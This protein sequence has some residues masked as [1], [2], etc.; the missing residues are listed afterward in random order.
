MEERDL[1]PWL[2]RDTLPLPLSVVW[3]Q[4]QLSAGF[5]INKCAKMAAGLI[6]FPVELKWLR[7]DH[8]HCPWNKISRMIAWSLD[9]ILDNYKHTHLY[10][11]IRPRNIKNVLT[12][13]FSIMKQTSGPTKRTVSSDWICQGDQ[14]QLDLLE[15]D[16]RT[17]RLLDSLKGLVLAGSIKAAGSIVMLP[18]KCLFILKI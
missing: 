9:V 15:P 7:N 8:I 5:Q 12:I 18:R 1:P 13:A 6:C 14:L 16:H 3:I 17:I 11:F 4:S 2:Y 10:L